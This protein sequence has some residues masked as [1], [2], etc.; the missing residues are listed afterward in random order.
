MPPPS[1]QSYFDQFADFRPDSTAAF[2]DEFSRCMSSQG[3][4]PSSQ[5]YRKERTVAISHELK[6]L[7]SQPLQD[8]EEGDESEAPAAS[9][10]LGVYQAMC[11]EVGLEAHDNIQDCVNDLRTKVLVNIPDFIDARRTGEKVKVWDDFNAFRDYTLQDEHRIDLQ[12][13]KKD[14]GFLAVLL[15][16]LW[17]GSGRPPH[18]NSKGARRGMARGSGRGVAKRVRT[19]KVTVAFSS[20]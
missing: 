8:I 12:E 9:E 20:S 16:K 7:Y 10:K 15:R 4:L 5:E 2:E 6:F 1:S 17:N 14:E 11:R 19:V 3:V 13:A 18:R